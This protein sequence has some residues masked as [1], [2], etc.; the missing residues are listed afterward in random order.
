MGSTNTDHAATLPFTRITGQYGYTSGA[1]GLK[2]AIQF[3][4]KP[5]TTLFN[6]VCY[7]SK[8]E[9]A[10]CRKCMQLDIIRLSGISQMQTNVT[11]FPQA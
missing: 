10:I 7:E 3:Y 4:C 8:E 6:E 2:P 1:L 11:F 9:L 5:T